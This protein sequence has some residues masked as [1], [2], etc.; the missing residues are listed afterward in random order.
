MVK[1]PN[2]VESDWFGK[3]RKRFCY[4]DSVLNE[5]D[6]H[7]GITFYQE[8]F[9]PETGKTTVKVGCDYQHFGD[10][11][12]QEEDFGE[13]LL[14]ADGVLLVNQFEALVERL[15]RESERA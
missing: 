14:N 2:L 4:E 13:L 7:G 9:D 6:F 15:Q 3:N 1:S 8:T 5:L 10:E 12:Y 11:H